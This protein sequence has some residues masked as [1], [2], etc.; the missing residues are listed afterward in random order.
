M[1]FF[2]PDSQDFV[3]PSFDFGM[4]TRSST[5]VRQ[6]DDLYP[7]EI[8]AEPPYDGILVSKAIVYGHGGGAGKY[9]GAQRQRFLRM[10]VRDYFRLHD[11][12]LQTMGDCGAFTYVKESRPPYS[13]AE[14]ADFYHNS[15]F[16]FGLSVDHII[17]AYRSALDTHV[18]GLESVP[19]EWR[20]RQEITLELAE[21]FFQYHQSRKFRFVP[22]G[23]AQGWSPDSYAYAVEKLQD[24]GYSH[25][26][27]GGFV[28]LKTH[29]VLTCLEK[30]SRVRKSRTSFHLLGITRCE[31]LELFESY[32]VTSFDS[33]APLRR[34]F[35]DDKH[36]YY[37]TT[38]TYTAIRV[39]QIDAN[40]ELLRK[41]Q[42][43]QINQEEARTLEQQCLEALT[44]YDNDRTSL[45]EVLKHLREYENL[46]DGDTDRTEIYRRTLTD[47]PWK[48]CP[49]DIC[50]KIGI[51]VI[52]FRGAERNRR[53]G[54]HNL[55]VFY[56]ALRDER[57]RTAKVS[58]SSS[59]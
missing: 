8:F 17:L 45:N 11:S 6:R 21:Q 13:A 4:E 50:K 59:R 12:S 1:K 18:C 19:K 36:N 48:F 43:G 41:I 31:N 51:H 26:A 46:H 49:C 10:G 30:A 42:A 27:F 52:I 38:G 7:H 34:A 14:V 47:T 15:G 35:K 5:R 57:R 58:A 54:F 33:T 32:G 39:P 22:V 2:F 44:D 20:V 3:D 28:P 55:F 25:I 29:E 40:P 9:S 37:S 53:R 24:L 23:I 56:N 16:D